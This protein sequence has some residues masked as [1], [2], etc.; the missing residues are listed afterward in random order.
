MQVELM[1]QA[2]AEA[3]ASNPWL[4]DSGVCFSQSIELFQEILQGVQAPGRIVL[5]TVAP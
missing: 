5:R 2:S 3:C 4:G 1:W